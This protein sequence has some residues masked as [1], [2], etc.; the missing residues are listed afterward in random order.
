MASALPSSLLFDLDDQLHTGQ[1]WE[2]YLKHFE[3]LILA[4]DIKDDTRKRVL[5]LHCIG[6]QV[7]EIFDILPNTG[8]TK[9]CKKTCDALNEYFSPKRNLAYEIFKFRKTVQQQGETLD[10]CHTRLQIAVKYC[11]FTNVTAEINSQ[12][13]LG[14]TNKKIRRHAFRNPDLTLTQLLA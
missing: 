6:E 8:H 2:K 9:D 5:L 3:N 1:I 14:T 11:E 4:L 10:K 12:L 7:E 13:E